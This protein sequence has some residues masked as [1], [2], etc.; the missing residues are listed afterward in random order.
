MSFFSRIK[1][2]FSTESNLNEKWSVPETNEELEKLFKES[3]G[4]NLIYKHS[5]TC[6]TCIFAKKRV[7]ELLN[8]DVQINSFHFIEVR[9][10]RALSNFVSEK[11]GIKHESPQ[12][13]L[14]YNGEVKWHASHSSIEVDAILNTLKE[15][16]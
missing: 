2:T 11:T 12:A 7:E 1:N 9:M 6:M 13:I 5:N 8:S 4:L 10:S 14:L 15:I 16:N 3:S